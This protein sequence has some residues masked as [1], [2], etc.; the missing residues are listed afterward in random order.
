MNATQPLRMS[1]L[2][3]RANQQIRRNADPLAQLANHHQRE[4]ERRRFRISETRWRGRLREE[5]ES[6]PGSRD[7]RSWLNFH[8]RWLCNHV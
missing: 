5:R 2:P 8:N 7:H 6:Y 3:G 1:A 4:S